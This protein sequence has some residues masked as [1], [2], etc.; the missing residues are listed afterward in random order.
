MPA[1]VVVNTMI[2]DPDAYETY[3]GLAATA[4]ES[5]GGRYLARGGDMAVLEG[6]WQPERMVIVEFDSLDAAGAWYE[7]DEYRA[8]RNTRE[9]AATMQMVAV[10][11]A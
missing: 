11:G 3:R 7:S 8:A 9:G 6:D 2:E 10:A 4:V 1:Y 5:H